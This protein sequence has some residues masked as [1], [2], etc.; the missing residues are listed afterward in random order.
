M[1]IALS[2]AALKQLSF[3]PR[4]SAS[5]IRRDTF[6]NLARL[7]GDQRFPVAEEF[8]HG[9]EGGIGHGAGDLDPQTNVTRRTAES[10]SA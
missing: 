8:G 1:V 6:D 5:K 3:E 7:V 9:H 10:N 2:A 4:W